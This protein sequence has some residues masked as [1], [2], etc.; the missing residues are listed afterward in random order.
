M[1]KFLIEVYIFKKIALFFLSSLSGVSIDLIVF[2]VL[3]QITNHVFL[4]NTISSSLAIATTYYVSTSILF[5]ERKKNKKDF[6][7]IFVWYVIS[8]NFFSFFIFFLHTQLMF[9]LI[10]C[11]IISLPLSFVVNFTFNSLYFK[12]KT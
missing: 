1:R 11:K 12:R 7:S 5:T 3:G 2:Y 8:I 9:E 10:I 4:V 6:L